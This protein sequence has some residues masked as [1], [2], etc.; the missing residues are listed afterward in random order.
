VTRHQYPIFSQ[1]RSVSLRAILLGE[2]EYLIQVSWRGK[3]RQSER[4]VH[5]QR[6]ILCAAHQIDNPR[7]PAFCPA[8]QLVAFRLF[9]L[10]RHP[11]L[12]A[13]SRATSLQD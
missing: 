12:C 6:R 10:S 1:D 5:D 13:G 7:I 9:F 11:S 4:K 2:N 3:T 8:C